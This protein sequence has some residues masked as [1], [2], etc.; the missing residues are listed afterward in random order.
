MSA[1]ACN[2][3]PV[4]GGF[5]NLPRRGAWF[6]R[7]EVQGEIT[8]SGGPIVISSDRAEFRGTWLRGSTDGATTTF[9]AIG[10]AGGLRKTLPAK[11]WRQLPLGQILQ[12]LCSGSKEALSPTVRANVLANSLDS[13]SRIEESMVST[14]DDICDQFG[15]LWRMTPSGKL[16][17]GD[18]QEASKGPSDYIA[19]EPHGARGFDLIAPSDL[20]VVPGMQLSGKTVN[21]VEYFLSSSSLRAHVWHDYS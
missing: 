12:W 6:A 17:V 13:Y 21:A 15:L 19:L 14:L 10:G 20:N 5:L 16:W 1:I 11:H 3:F 4:S 7:L 18:G 2:G 9:S 8:A